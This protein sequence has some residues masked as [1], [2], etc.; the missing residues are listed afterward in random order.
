MYGCSCRQSDTVDLLANNRLMC[1]GCF[2]SARPWWTESRGKVR[3]ERECP[4]K[5]LKSLCQSMLITLEKLSPSC[6]HGLSDT[7]SSYE[8][9]PIGV[10]VDVRR[11]EGPGGNR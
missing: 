11:Y 9:E 10:V 4:Q 7:L 3:G 8:R 1:S 5:G 2:C 6:F